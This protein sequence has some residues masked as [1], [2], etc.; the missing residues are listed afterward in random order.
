[1]KIVLGDRVRGKVADDVRIES[2]RECVLNCLFA[3]KHYVR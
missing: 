2:S 3:A 1:M